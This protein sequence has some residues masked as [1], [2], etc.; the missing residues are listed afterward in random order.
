MNQIMSKQSSMLK[1]KGEKKEE[2]KKQPQEIFNFFQ[3]KSL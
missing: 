2:K 1:I 3:N